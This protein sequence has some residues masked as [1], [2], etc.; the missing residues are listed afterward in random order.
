[1]IEA[2]GPRRAKFPGAEEYF[3]LN[4]VI[5]CIKG[6]IIIFRQPLTCD[7]PVGS[8]VANRAGIF[9]IW[10]RGDFHIRIA[11]L[12]LDG[13]HREDDPPI[14]YHMTRNGVC[15]Y[16]YEHPEFDFEAKN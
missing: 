15:Y 12:T 4:P 7:V 8:K 10:E 3:R 14:W 2:A 16:K 6:N 13:G 11:N 1:M 9:T 5:K